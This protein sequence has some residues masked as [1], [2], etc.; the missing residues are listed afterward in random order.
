MSPLCQQC[1]K[2]EKSQELCFC[3]CKMLNW[4][5]EVQFGPALFKEMILQICKMTLGLWDKDLCYHSATSLSSLC[6]QKDALIDPNDAVISL[7]FWKVL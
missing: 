4:G 2:K 1:L 3:F 5:R 6:N 7:V